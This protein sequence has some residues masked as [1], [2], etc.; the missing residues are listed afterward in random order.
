MPFDSDIVS[1]SSGGNT[2]Q[3]PPPANQQPP[4]QATP[5]TQQDSSVSNSQAA[6]ANGSPAQAQPA[7]QQNPQQQI[8]SNQPPADPNAD[9]PAVK[10]ASLLYSAA[11]ALTGGPRYAVSIDDSGNRIKTPVPV[12]GKQLGLALALEAIK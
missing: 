11:Q 3:T 8:V 5:V 2:P 12:S 7:Q 4:Q 6:P 9:H 1:N 10:R